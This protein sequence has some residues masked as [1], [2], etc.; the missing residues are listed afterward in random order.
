[1]QRSHGS[2]YVNDH[3]QT[4]EPASEKAQK[5]TLERLNI[6]FD[7]YASEQELYTKGHVAA[8]LKHLQDAGHTREQGGALWLNTAPYGDTQDRV[9]VRASGE[10]T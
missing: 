3:L 9:L 1:M 6:H 4:A 10:A 5:E 8:L 2:F 7:S